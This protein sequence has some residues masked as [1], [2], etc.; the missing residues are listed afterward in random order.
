MGPILNQP[1]SA[2]VTSIGRSRVQIFMIEDIEDAFEQF[3]DLAISII[4]TLSKR[5][6]E[7]DMRLANH[8]PAKP[9]SIKRPVKSS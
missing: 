8:I 1:R 3:P 9:G 4:N 5:L 6:F 7:T 2:T